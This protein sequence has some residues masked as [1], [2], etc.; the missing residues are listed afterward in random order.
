[1]AVYKHIV[2]LIRKIWSQRIEG[3]GLSAVLTLNHMSSPL[4]ISQSR[5]WKK[6]S[7]KVWIRTG[8]RDG[9]E[10]EDA[11]IERKRIADVHVALGMKQLNFA[12]F[13]YAHILLIFRRRLRYTV[14]TY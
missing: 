10:D 1:M 7:V 11:L 13:K 4:F 6:A 12:P 9:A 8:K 5:A 3:I 2:R 14:Y